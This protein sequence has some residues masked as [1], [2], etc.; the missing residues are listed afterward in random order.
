MVA[1]FFVLNPV[2][3]H[4]FL[5]NWK[6]LILLGSYLELLVKT[7]SLPPQLLKNADFL[8]LDVAYITSQWR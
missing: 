3:A 7:V 2:S 4:D 6:K 5:I 8:I 1:S